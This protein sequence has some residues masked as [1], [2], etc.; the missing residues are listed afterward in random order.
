MKPSAFE[1]R[2]LIVAKWLVTKT[3]T[4]TVLRVIYFLETLDK[5][6]IEIPSEKFKLFVR[7]KSKDD[8]IMDFKSEQEYVKI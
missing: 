6:L 3:I 4:I 8:L 7:N 2:M 5:T 1:S